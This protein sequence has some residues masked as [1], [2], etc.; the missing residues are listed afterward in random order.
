[1]AVIVSD[2]E[3]QLLYLRSEGVSSD[4]ADFVNLVC[5]ELSIPIRNCSDHLINVACLAEIE[6]ELATG[7]GDGRQ[8]LLIAG[9]YLEEQVT[10]CALHG[11]AIGFE[12]FLLKDFIA[13]RNNRHSQ[14]FDMRL[15]Q[16]GAVPTTL[17]QLMYEW[18]ALEVS[19]DRQKVIT[20]LLKVI[21]ARA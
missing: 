1:M 15:F 4:E 11:L 18:L 17:R 8:R 2:G 21:D 3:C 20:Q 19:P 7:A 12:V 14:A 16:A 10:T 6:S 13:A 9:V 5:S